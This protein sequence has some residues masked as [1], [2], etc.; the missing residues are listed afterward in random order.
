M[1]APRQNAGN[2]HRRTARGFTLVEL[3]VAMAILSI[4]T[5]ALFM[6]FRASL[7]AY[8]ST[9]RAMD[10]S[11]VTQTAFRVLERDV[12][13]GFAAKHYGDASSFFGCPYG[14]TMICTLEAADV[15]AYNTARVSY[16]VHS[17]AGG[18]VVDTVTDGPDEYLLTFGLIRYIEPGIDTLSN[19]PVEW[20]DY[21]QST[22]DP[23]WPDYPLWYEL[24]QIYQQF[25]PD[26]NAGAG[27]D[28]RQVP[29]AEFEAM[30]EAKKHELWLAMLGDREEPFGDLPRLWDDPTAPG[31]NWG[32]G[33]S[34]ATLW[35][36]KYPEDYLIAEGVVQARPQTE[37]PDG[38]S[39]VMYNGQSVK[40][41][42]AFN[43]VHWFEYGYTPGEVED[44]ARLGLVQMLPFWHAVNDSNLGVAP[45]TLSGEPGDINYPFI[46]LYGSPLYPYPPSL[47]AVNMP[48]AF[49]APNLGERHYVRQL[50]HTFQIPVGYRRPL[51]AVE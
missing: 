40:L 46:N 22:W 33:P 11:E 24:N 34:F 3:L 23:E 16:V 31:T 28:Y 29:A 37:F 18:S 36:G 20:P 49:R 39:T 41:G 26:P 7:G 10:A 17:F 19:Y 43:D 32:G 47:V 27:A 48:F 15:Y 21:T 6:L 45:D 1:T 30:I 25:G 38:Y 4:L 5:L 44:L 50:S 14:M 42:D 2:G 12:V 35:D 8:R 9:K 51:M 13:Q